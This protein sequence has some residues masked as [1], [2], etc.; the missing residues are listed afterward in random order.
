MTSLPASPV[1]RL[2]GRQPQLAVAAVHLDDLDRARGTLLLL[3]GDPGI[4]KTRL[5]E[6]IAALARER[7]ARTVWASGWQGDGAPPLWPWVQILRELAGSAEALDQPE[8]ET[9]TASSARFAQLEAVVEQIRTASSD[10]PLVVVIDDLQWV[11]GASIRVLA[12]VAAAVR[13]APCL[14]VG[15]YRANEVP[16]DTLAELARVGSTLAIPR[17]P[18]AAAVELLRTAVGSDL[19]PAAAEAVVAR[20]GGNPLFVWE[21]GQLMAQSGR[22]DVV[23]ATVPVAV[24]AVIERRLARLSE[25][26]MALLRVA[27]VAGDPFSPATVAEIGEVGADEATAAL[28][29]AAHAGVLTGT[30]APAGYAFSHGL[31]RDV[32][33][34]GLDSSRRSELHRRAA[35]ALE[36]RLATDPSLHAVVA[37]HLAQ[38]GGPYA[39][40]ASR[41]W[42][43]AAHHALR[44]VAYEDAASAF[45]RAAAAGRDE[46]NRYAALLIAQGD[47]LLL[48]G[49]LEAARALLRQ[50]VTAARAIPNPEL[51]ARAVLSMGTG[52]VA[53]E[54][55][56]ASDEQAELAGDALA[57]L[58]P[59][60]TRLRAMLLSRLSVAAARPETQDLARRRA[61][62]AVAIAEQ[63]GDPALIGQA[64]AALNDALAGPAHTMVRRDN[65]DTII[66]LAVTAGDRSLELLGYRFRIVA[67]L[68]AGDFAA[69]DRD[70]VAF[71]R[72]AEALRQ[73]LIGWYVPLFRGMRALLRGDLDGA[74]RFHREVAAAAAT[75][76]SLNAALMEAVLRLPIE[77]ARGMQPD[78]EA[79][80]SLVDADPAR[81]ASMASGL[82]IVRWL[83]GD[84]E[85]AGALMRLHTD[86]GL[87]RLGEDS[88]HLTTLTLFGRVAAGLGDGDAAATVYEKLQPHAGLWAVDGIA[89]Y[90]WGPVDLELG[91]L[92]IT[93]ERWPEA[94]EHLARARRSVEQA[95]AP[96]LAA[97]VD[98]LVQLVDAVGGAS[99]ATANMEG[100]AAAGTGVFHGEGQF[101]TVAFGGRTIRMKDAKG[102]RDLAQLVAEPGRELHVLDLASAGGGTEPRRD[103]SD[104][105]PGDL[106]EVLDARARAEYRRRLAEL[107]DELAD[108]EAMQ[109]ADRAEHARSEREFLAT[110]LASAL[111]LGGRPRRAGDPVERARKAVSGRIRMAIGRIGEEHPALARHLTHAVRTGTYC[112]YEPE[113][114]TDW[115]T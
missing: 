16:R 90:C 52:P 87:A 96:L 49:D 21:F 35:A 6:E 86:N 109:D 46:P 114:A 99:G 73:P 13:T 105:A 26:D 91:R 24:A 25:R 113:V 63:E 1:R 51:M 42:E 5:A 55:P 4:G 67:D 38:A 95:G 40:E 115:L 61:E 30:N 31:L 36:R 101:W 54:V 9:V 103:G 71:T 29:A 22:L 85:G 77:T 93:M 48:A 81:W 108:A 80:E 44:V 76:G 12:F 56:I 82:A 83:A 97:D 20:S 78:V 106:G 50:A 34:D 100:D 62:E 47:A 10:N 39:D 75:T 23:P 60:A 107:D 8:P 68:E 72:L 79:F 33:I 98:A 43:Q 27:A 88:E 65:A 3:A 84:R 15:T 53:W 17:L 92:A 32:V 59:D 89:G 58:P 111:G 11:D 7:G 110:E 37:D 45:G 14:L 102:L 94:T 57:L 2:V 64:L 28:D 18:D 70:I 19:T 104:A 69:V 112:V 41:H 66:E 74:E